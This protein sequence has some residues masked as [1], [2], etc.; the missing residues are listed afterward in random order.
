MFT[1]LYCALVRPHLEYAMQEN[2]P[3]LRADINQFDDLILAFK[4]FK[5]EVDLN[6]SSAHPEPAYEGTPTE[7]CKDQAVFDAGAVLSQFGL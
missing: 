4:I 6:S 3:P 7:Y 2:A 1:P 5:G